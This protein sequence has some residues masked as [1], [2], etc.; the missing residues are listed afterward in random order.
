MLI[1]NVRKTAVNGFSPLLRNFFLCNICYYHF[2]RFKFS[3][4]Y[5]QTI[6][7]RKH[8][9]NVTTL[10]V[11]YNCTQFCTTR[12]SSLLY[13]SSFEIIIIFI[14]SKIKR[15]FCISTMA[16]LLILWY[17]CCRRCL[18]LLPLPPPPPLLCWRFDVPIATNEWSI[19]IN[20]FHFHFVVTI[21]SQTST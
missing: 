20:P 5:Q 11:V 18:M 6:P 12:D 9:V 16:F 19:S 21:V 1:I 2:L 14:S 17:C 8:T 13:F 10:Q 7:R 4:K 15:I 3:G